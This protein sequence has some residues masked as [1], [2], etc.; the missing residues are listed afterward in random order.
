MSRIVQ[1]IEVYPP[2]MNTD[3]VI[4][5]EQLYSTPH[6]CPCCN[7]E[8]FNWFYDEKINESVKQ[9][10]KACDGSGQVVPCISIGWIP[11]KMVASKM[12]D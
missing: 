6:I 3:G 11:L 5:N 2:R 9:R 8:G 12:N 10:C 7:G 4:K 1:N